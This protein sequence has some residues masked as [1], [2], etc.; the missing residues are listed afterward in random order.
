MASFVNAETHPSFPSRLLD[1]KEAAAYLKLDEKTITRWA[2]KAYIPA[3]PLGEGKRRFWRFYEHEVAAWLNRQ[4]NGAECQPTVS[5]IQHFAVWGRD[6]V[7]QLQ[8]PLGP[9]ARAPN[10]KTIVNGRS[11]R[12][13]RGSL[14]TMKHK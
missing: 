6:T 13:Q 7:N 11:R 8:P 12:Y 10:T 4:S 1:P 2:R 9:V 5:S 3:H 14:S